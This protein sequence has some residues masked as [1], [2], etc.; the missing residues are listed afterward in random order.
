MVMGM[1]VGVSGDMFTRALEHVGPWAREQ[2]AS[3]NAA[4]VTDVGRQS[5]QRPSTS[6]K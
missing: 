3:D 4:R 5:E 6:R 1:S 2:K